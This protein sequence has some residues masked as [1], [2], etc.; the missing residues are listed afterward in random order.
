MINEQWNMQSICLTGRAL[1]R[2]LFNKFSTLIEPHLSKSQPHFVSVVCGFPKDLLNSKYKLGKFGD[3]SWF[4]TTTRTADVIGKFNQPD[5]QQTVNNT[6]KNRKVIDFIFFFLTFWRLTK[7]NK[8]LIMQSLCYSIASK[9][10]KL[11]VNQH[12]LIN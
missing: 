12:N 4:M 9:S 2:V 11:I 8:V 5:L 7:K 6:K 3:D 1:S 10:Y